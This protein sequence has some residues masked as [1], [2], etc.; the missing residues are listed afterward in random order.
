MQA[1]YEL[2]LGRGAVLAFFVSGPAT[3]LSA[4]YAFS[5]GYGARFLGAYLFY[6]LSIAFL[7]G[8]LFTLIG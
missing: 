4:L 1:L 2:G 5:S 6:T 3:K 7:A 8:I